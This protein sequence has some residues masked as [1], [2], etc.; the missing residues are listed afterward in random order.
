MQPLKISILGDFWDCQI[1]RGRLYLWTM[2]GRILT[3]KW[4]EF[5]NSLA[6]DEELKLA[7]ICGFCRGDYLYNSAFKLIFSDVEIANMLRS[8]F[9][10]L[11]EKRFEFS[12]KDVAKY[13]YGE[14]ATPLQELSADSDIYNNRLYIAT[15]KGLFKT[16]VHRSS[17]RYPVSS[18][19]ERIW[20]CR[21]LSLRSSTNG[22]LALSAGDDGLF[23]LDTNDREYF[24]NTY[25]SNQFK[26]IEKNLHMLSGGHSFMANWNYSSI[27]STSNVDDS[28]MIL[29][30]WE[31]SDSDRVD[32]RFKEIVKERALFHLAENS[33]FSQLS[34]G[35]DNKIYRTSH[36]GGIE[37]IDYTQKHVLEKE[38]S[39]FTKA[40]HVEF[41]PWKGDVISGG[42]AYFG[43]IVE[44]ENALVVMKDEN[45]FFNI[46][47]SVTRWRVYPRSIRYEN[48]LHVISDGKIDIYS[49]NH[50]YFR[51]Q[52]DKKIGIKYFERDNRRPLPR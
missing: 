49:F 34:W 41:Q 26:K 36:K 22:R 6:V 50:D 19:P 14:Q 18:R 31:K 42:V 12:V 46:P 29:F 52:E 10:K 21:L 32:L 44:C 9:E 24:E 43:V 40:Q 7:L 38:S 27:Y 13:L 39:A 28:Y 15:D 4:D 5:I 2:D 1:Y 3:Y 51:S 30:G 25:R 45:E 20:D 17:K 11:S 48:H 8:K 33:D 23:E 37:I 47:D 16:T 35:C